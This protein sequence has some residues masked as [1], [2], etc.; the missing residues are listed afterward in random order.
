V[1]RGWLGVDIRDVSDEQYGRVARNRFGYDKTTGVF[2]TGPI[3][4]T[5][6]WGKLI[7]GDIITAF[8]GKEIATVDDLQKM[9]AASEPGKVA[10][11]TVFRDFKSIEGTSAGSRPDGRKHAGTGE[12]PAP[13]S[14]SRTSN[15][16]STS[17]PTWDCRCR[18]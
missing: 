7:G 18:T 10:K 9:V 17:P 8:N 14:R 12:Q 15:W 3:R 4:N 11:L 5:P 13:R 2:V 16:K 1:I 6:S